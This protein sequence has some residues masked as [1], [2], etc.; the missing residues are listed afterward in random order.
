MS[1]PNLRHIRLFCA[2]VQL[3]SMS[4]AAEQIGVTQPAAS[5]GLARMEAIFGAPLI[6][7]R[8]GTARAT[9]EGRIVHARAQRALE[10]IRTGVA[11]LRGP[12]GGQA[13]ETRLTLPH[14]RALAAFAEGGSFSA[15]ARILR[16]SEPAVHRTARDAEATLRTPLF[17]GSGRAIR[18]SSAGLSAARWSRLALNELDNAA[19]E[20]RELRGRFEGHVALGTLPLA[21]TG[22]VPRA[23]TAVGARHALASFSIAEGRYEALLRDLEMGRIDILV[24]ALRPHLASSTLEQEE[25]FTYRLSVVAR[26]GHPL[27]GRRNLDVSDLAEYP[28]VMAREGTPSRAVFTALASRFPPGKPALRS[29]ETGSLGVARGILM[30]SDH[31]A[32]F[33]PLQIDYEMQAGFLSP[34]DFEVDDPGLA[35]GITTRKRWL[36][37]ALQ[38]EF[39][40][41]LRT[42]ARAAAHPQTPQ[43][44]ANTTPDL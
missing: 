34:L 33:S 28:W 29:V 22:I 39:I 1:Y 7:T 25:L 19:A 42:V 6:D 24:G 4:R 43:G 5:Q 9:P 10:L 8:S 23:I 12:G 21:R 38:R 30:E 3:G 20:I 26:A 2:C 17:E 27:A 32:L 15:A 31:L 36:P 11:R 44:P 40:D 14:L 41:T 16:Q 13:A 37:T 35:I 18:L